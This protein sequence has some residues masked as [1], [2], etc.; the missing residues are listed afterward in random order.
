MDR[1]NN[2]NI[3]KS[4]NDI[5]IDIGK[6]DLHV[7]NIKSINQIVSG[8]NRVKNKYA[9]ITMDFIKTHAIF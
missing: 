5:D 6:I 3:E 7:K 1:I 2:Y 4:S 8:P 9:K